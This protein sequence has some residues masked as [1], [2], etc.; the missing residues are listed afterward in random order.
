[1]RPPAHKTHKTLISHQM[2]QLVQIFVAHSNNTTQHTSFLVSDESQAILTGG[3]TSICV[4]SLI[5][6]RINQHL[7]RYFSVGLHCFSIIALQ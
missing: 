2:A 3:R 7:T 4:Y 5:D 1:M 6:C